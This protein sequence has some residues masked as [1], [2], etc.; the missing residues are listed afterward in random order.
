MHTLI[1]KYN[2]QGSKQANHSAE[3]FEA[4]ADGAAKDDCE[5]IGLNQK[6]LDISSVSAA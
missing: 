5:I 3:T 1:G 4:Y 2:Q 6:N